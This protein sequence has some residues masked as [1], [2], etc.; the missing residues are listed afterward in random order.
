MNLD[1]MLEEH[2]ISDLNKIIK[3]YLSESH[4]CL[5]GEK[6]KKFTDKDLLKYDPEL[7]VQYINKFNEIFLFSTNAEYGNL[8]NM[9]W[10]LENKFKYDYR[11]FES[12]ALHG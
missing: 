9:K 8:E 6:N 3:Q 11:T 1:I 12:A 2:L 10:L 5:L 4:L 7:M